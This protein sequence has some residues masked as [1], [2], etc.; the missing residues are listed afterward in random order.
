M[1][2]YNGEVKYILEE[3]IRVAMQKTACF[4]LN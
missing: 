4:Y 2:E 3:V 1:P